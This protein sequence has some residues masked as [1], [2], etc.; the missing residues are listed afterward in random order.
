MGFVAGALKHIENEDCL[1]TAFAYDLIWPVLWKT[2]QQSIHVSTHNSAGITNCKH[3]ASC[4][5]PIQHFHFLVCRLHEGADDWC[6]L[7][8]PPPGLRFPQTCQLHEDADD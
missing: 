2:G 1:S 3:N 7:T 5:S 6:K 8:M 4:T